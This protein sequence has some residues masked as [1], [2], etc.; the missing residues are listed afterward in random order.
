MGEE[1]LSCCRVI[2]GEA[3]QMPGLTVDRF[4]DILVTQTLSYGME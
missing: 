2:F 1:D 4:G 3:D